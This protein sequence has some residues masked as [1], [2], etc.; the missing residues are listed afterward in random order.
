MKT[1][2]FQAEAVA[3]FELHA[4]SLVITATVVVIYVVLNTIIAHLVKRADQGE[5]RQGAALKVIKTARLITAFFGLLAIMVA[6]GIDFSS[7][8]LFATTTVTLLG[9]ALFASWSLLSNITAYFVLLFH[10]SFT[11]GTFV[12]VLEADNYVEGYVADLTLFSIELVT[13]DGARVV[14]PNNILLARVAVVDPKDRMN[15]IGK[16][17]APASL[18]TTQETAPT[19]STER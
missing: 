5:S 14:Y 15:G 8:A 7:V 13:E 1:D 9:V 19:P 12:R 6:W 16:Y 11:R 3:W 17:P 10:R 18:P 4:T 2:S